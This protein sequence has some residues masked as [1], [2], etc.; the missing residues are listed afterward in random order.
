[1]NKRCSPGSGESSK[2]FRRVSWFIAALMVVLF[3]I[4]EGSALT[5]STVLTREI[6][7]MD[8]CRKTGGPA[9]AL[10]ATKLFI[11]HNSAD[12]DTGVHGAFDGL[13]WVSLCVYD[14]SG[15]LV[16]EVEPERQLKRQ[17]ISGIFFESA[18]PSNQEVPIADILARFPA[19]LYS[20]RGLT[21]DGERITGAATFTHDIP[22]PPIIIFPQ[23]G[24]QVS[25][26]GRVVMWSHVT[27]TL[28][29]APLNRTGYQVIITKN[30]PD[31][32]HGFSRPTFDVHLPPTQTMLSVPSEFLE[33]GTSYEL[34]V[35]ALE[36]SG[37]QTISIVN[38]QTE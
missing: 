7:R 6:D 29:G 1:M 9:M 15:R 24:A 31:D 30:V 27:T 16:L 13:D 4:F 14:P 28:T 23:E 36:V 34:E 10:P 32:P 11:E 17:S 22:A 25:A 19:G 26:S 8:G 21:K 38:F 2:L 12:E 18:E 3:C 33:R 35:L 20:V 37:N 5:S